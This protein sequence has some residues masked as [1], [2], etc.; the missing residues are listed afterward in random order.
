MAAVPFVVL[1]VQKTPLAW[2]V[3]SQPLRSLRCLPLLRAAAGPRLLL[4]VCA[5]GKAKQ[6]SFL[7]CLGAIYS[8]RGGLDAVLGGQCVRPSVMS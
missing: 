4:S 7:F 8:A 1:L 2:H 6:E 3:C 5:R